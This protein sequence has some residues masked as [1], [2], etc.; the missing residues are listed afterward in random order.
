MIDA[1]TVFETFKWIAM[2]VSGVMAVITWF[3]K[4]LWE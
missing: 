1:S 4:N 2:L 3:K